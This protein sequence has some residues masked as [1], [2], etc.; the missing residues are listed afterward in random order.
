L[1]GSF[2]IWFRLAAAQGNAFAEMFPS[3]YCTRLVATL[4]IAQ[5]IGLVPVPKCLQ[6]PLRCFQRSHKAASPKIA[7][8]PPC[9]CHTVMASCRC[10][11]LISQAG[12][13]GL[14]PAIKVGAGK[15]ANA[16]LAKFTSPS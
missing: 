3:E 13:T 7:A 10:A 1:F 4:C 16:F 5:D 8:L 12:K 14:A 9:F 11:A 6:I 2:S 15:D